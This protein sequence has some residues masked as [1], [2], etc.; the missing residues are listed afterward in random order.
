[1]TVAPTGRQLY[2][3][4][5]KKC[6]TRYD[7]EAGA[8]LDKRREGRDVSPAAETMIGLHR[9]E[10]IEQCLKDVI[11]D[12]IPGDLIETGVWRGGAAIFMRAVLAAYGVGD[13]TVWVADS[14]EGLPKP[15]PEKY[16]SDRDSRLWKVPALRVSLQEVKANF[17]KYGL[18]DDNVRF[19][20]GWFR[21]TLPDAPV[22]RLALLRLDGDLYEST[23]QALD[24]LYPK[25]SPGGFA[26]VD[27][28]GAA[29]ATAE[30]V[31]DYRARHGIDD[32]LVRI[33]WTGVFWRRS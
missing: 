16:P 3:D 28:Y 7:L 11:Q 15:D 24:S 21:D 12:E 26:I 13:R 31:N 10:N 22:E 33:D 30:A 4:L 14:F 19:L 27:D 20:P 29:E 2:L 32:E 8:D 5:L 23:I 25:L 9:L 18:L 1:M 17:A 6:L